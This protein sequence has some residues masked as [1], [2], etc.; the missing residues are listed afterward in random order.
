[1]ST[2]RIRFLTQAETQNPVVNTAPVHDI[3]VDIVRCQNGIT[4]FLHSADIS[5][6]FFVRGLPVR[7]FL[8]VPFLQG[9][10]QSMA[11]TVFRHELWITPL[12]KSPAHAV[13]HRNIMLVHRK[14]R[15]LCHGDFLDMF[16]F[17]VS[18]RSRL[19]CLQAFRQRADGRNDAA[20][21]DEESHGER[22]P[23]IFHRDSSIRF[24]FCFTYIIR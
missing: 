14:F 8:C 4:G 24:Y 19:R 2:A 23:Q 5:A 11:R 16:L 17:F 12:I 13:L 7:A 1:M 22:T 15:G 20:D 10:A 18:C 3:I 9:C 6:K 21:T